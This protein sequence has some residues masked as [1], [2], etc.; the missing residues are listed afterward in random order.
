[1]GS[2]S[3]VSCICP[4]RAPVD[5]HRPW[6]AEWTCGHPYGCQV[7]FSPRGL[8][9]TARILRN[10]FPDGTRP[11]F[12]PLELEVFHG[13]ADPAGYHDE[14]LVL[15]EAQRDLWEL[16]LQQLLAIV[17]GE[18]FLTPH[19]QRQWPTFWERLDYDL[20]DVLQD[21]LRL[22]EASRETG[23]PIHIAT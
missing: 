13:L 15:T 22:I 18:T 12:P 1:M 16:E 19:A 11:G 3:W 21:G 5:A 20:E 23:Q 8:L 14:E 10:L 17:R 9:R 4:G 2:W 7:A 6:G